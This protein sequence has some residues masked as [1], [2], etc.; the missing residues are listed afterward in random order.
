MKAWTRKILAG[1][2]ALVMA[3]SLV[4]CGGEEA[5][6]TQS[7]D[8][9]TAANPSQSSG[10]IKIAMSTAQ[11]GAL[12]EAGV[13]QV[14]AAQM[15][16]NEINEAGGI[17]GQQ[18]ELVVYD[19]KGDVTESTL[20]AQ[21]IVQDPEF[22]CVIGTLTSST[23][24]ATLPIYE[25]AGL[26]MMIPTANSSDIKGDNFIRMVLTSDVQGPQL[27]ACAVNN[28]DKQKLAIIYP[29]SDFGTGMLEICSNTLEKLGAEVVM[30]E[31]YT[32]GTD[33]D[34]SVHLSKLEKSGADGVL[35]LGDYNETSMIIAQA[36]RIENLSD[37][38]YF[39]DASIL[40]E[41]FLERVK[42]ISHEENCIVA[43]SYNPYDDRDLYKEFAQKLQD[44]FGIATN[45]PTVFTY[46]LINIMAQALEK[47]ATR[48]TLVET[49]KGMEFENMLSASGTIKFNADG[50]REALDIAIISVKDNAFYY[51]GNS[52]DMTGAMD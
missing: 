13:S 52:V 43:A 20:V 3:L 45:E 18:L 7:P 16:I 11:T 14:N 2:F 38:Q 8:A 50:N 12:A 24:L 42:D 44:Q 27:A 39:M 29:M 33:R 28:Y 22:L 26:P 34:F 31:P 46:D 19:D 37:M 47:G 6:S 32:A 35:L 9:T 23:T 4:S 36:D 21:R 41:V 5:P 51:T 15:A 17:N 40:S 10:T 49:I 48:E 30:A 25:A 1:V